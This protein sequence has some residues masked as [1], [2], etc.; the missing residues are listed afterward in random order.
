VLIVALT[1]LPTRQI[2][3]IFGEKKKYYGAKISTGMVDRMWK[4]KSLSMEAPFQIRIDFIW[5]L[6][7]L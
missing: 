7:Q 2:Y 3:T 6:I 5:I 1:G 4:K